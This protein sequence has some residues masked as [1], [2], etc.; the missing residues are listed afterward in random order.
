[1][2][3]T[4]LPAPNTTLRLGPWQNAKSVQEW[5]LWTAQK[6]TRNKVWDLLSTGCLHSTFPGHSHLIFTSSQ[7]SFQLNLRVRDTYSLHMAYISPAVLTDPAFLF[8]VTDYQQSV[9]FYCWVVFPCIDKPD[10]ACLFTTWWT[11]RLFVCV[12]MR[13]HVRLSENP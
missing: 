10:F 7:Y 6:R 1:M 2:T 11:F 12:C 5:W 9:P 4:G 3:H 8:R 13:S